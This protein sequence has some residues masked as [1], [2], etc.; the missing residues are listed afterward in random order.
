[1]EEELGVG[2]ADGD[3]IVAGGALDVGVVYLEVVGAG[4][5][6]RVG[7]ADCREDHEEVRPAEILALLHGG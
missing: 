3:G 4:A 6:P 2:L 7:G 1:M 5:S